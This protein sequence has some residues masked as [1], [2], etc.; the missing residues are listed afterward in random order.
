VFRESRYFTHI[1]WRM[2]QVRRA[3]RLRGVVLI[4]PLINISGI[5]FE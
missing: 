1:A 4:N 3:C 2:Q 5:V